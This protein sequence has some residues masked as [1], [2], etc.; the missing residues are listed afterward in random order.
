VLRD[1]VNE[2]VPQNPSPHPDRRARPQGEG[3][4][5]DELHC[6]LCGYSLYGLPE[7]RCPEC[8][9][10][11]TWDGLRAKMRRREAWFFEH[12]GT[13]RS[14]WQTR[15]RSLRPRK[16][17]RN[18]KP[19]WNIDTQRLHFYMLASIVLTLGLF[20]AYYF[21]L[22][23]AFDAYQ[24]VKQFGSVAATVWA[25]PSNAEIPSEFF[26]ILLLTFGIGGLLVFCF[27]HPFWLILSWSTYQR[28]IR[29]QQ[30]LRATTYIVDPLPWMMLAGL[31]WMTIVLCEGW[32]RDFPNLSF[33]L[34]SPSALSEHALLL[35]GIGFAFIAYRVGVASGKYLHLPHA[36]S[37]GLTYFV[38][39]SLTWLMV[40]LYVAELARF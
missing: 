18:L 17:W 4:K 16:F 33:F 20:L 22:P 25:S 26:H 21:V 12:A 35:T 40:V 39:I 31:A 1:S 9:Y 3:E 27:T 10:Q 8:G 37:V 5:I 13:Y 2:Q 15:M 32:W 19:A 36:F 30:L 14:F 6:P 23:A 29:P 11:F 28:A 7:P 34:G 24:N 38:I